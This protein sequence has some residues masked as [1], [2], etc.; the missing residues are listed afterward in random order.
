MERVV[1]RHEQLLLRVE[2]LREAWAAH[3][4]RL[5]AVLSSA[6]HAVSQLP[7]L[8]RAQNHEALAAEFGGAAG[9]AA[10]ALVGRH[11]ARVE[12]RL[13]EARGLLEEMQRACAGLERCWEEGRAFFASIR[14]RPSREQAGRRG[15]AQPSLLDCQQGL[16]LFAASYR[17][18]LRLKEA[19]V[20]SIS[21]GSREEDLQAI[22]GVLSD[23]P[24]ICTPEVTEMVQLL[25]VA[26]S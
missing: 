20:G 1:K 12:A 2:K 18:E 10:R 19:L 15:G 21:Y 7:A 24:N 14:P 16:R 8:V 5:V 17:D 6:A 3:Q 4:G 11:V 26:K 9:D 25:S 23:E 13:A 22:I